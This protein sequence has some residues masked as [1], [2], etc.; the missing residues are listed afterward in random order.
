[1]DSQISL[2]SF[3]CGSVVFHCCKA[4]MC[5]HMSLFCNLN[6][7]NI[8]FVFFYAASSC[9]YDLLNIRKQARIYVTRLESFINNKYNL[10]AIT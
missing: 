1:M 3:G 9:K 7:M 5:S 6:L 2:K 8:I 4:H 10:N